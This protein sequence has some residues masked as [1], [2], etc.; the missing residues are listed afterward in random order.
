[1][2]ERKLRQIDILSLCKPICQAEGIRLEKNDLSQY[3]SGKV[4]P[5]YAKLGVLS[6]ALG[7]EEAWL[8]GYDLP[9]TTSMEANNNDLFLLWFCN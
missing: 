4:L 3:L 2:E 1:M 6:K 5:G 7:V 8:L 9:K